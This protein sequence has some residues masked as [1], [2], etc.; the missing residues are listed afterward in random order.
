[1]QID[2]YIVDVLLPDLVGHDR[3]PGAFLTYL[4]LYRHRERS[5]VERSLREIAE[6]TGLSKRSVQSA[7]E[8][9]E[10]R[11]LIGIERPTATARGIYR[12]AQPWRRE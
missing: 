2:P 6:G 7:L 3:Q 11:G 12:V 10:A 9:L 4:F 8:T 5:G 1:M